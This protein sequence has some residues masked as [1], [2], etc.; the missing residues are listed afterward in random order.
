M[1]AKGNKTFFQLKEFFTEVFGTFKSPVT[2]KVKNR[3]CNV[4]SEP[5][6]KIGKSFKT[7]I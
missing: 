3:I 7:Q 1:L 5:R 4:H 6:F 2:E